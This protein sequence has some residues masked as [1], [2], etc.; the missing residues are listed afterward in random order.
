MKINWGSG[1]VLG[2]AGGLLSGF[3]LIGASLI[4]FDSPSSRQDPSD[5][6]VT[7]LG[8]ARLDEVK[9]QDS[10]RCVVAKNPEGVAVSCDWK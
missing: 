1:A 8:S 7:K 9:L 4:V 6:P 3:M 10:T 5:I 2:I